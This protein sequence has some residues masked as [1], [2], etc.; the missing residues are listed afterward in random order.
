MVQAATRGPQQVPASLRQT[1]SFPSS[2]VV[3]CVNTLY[4][5]N[6]E[7]V[8]C[9]SAMCEGD[10]QELKG[11]CA[12]VWMTVCTVPVSQRFKPRN[13]GIQLLTGHINEC[14]HTNVSCTSRL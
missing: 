4:S 9:A 2:F 1:H 12:T 10:L 5:M 14:Q 7:V 11:W 6:H 8:C 13:A 3:R